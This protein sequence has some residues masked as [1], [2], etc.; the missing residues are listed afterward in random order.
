MNFEAH[1][2]FGL[3]LH[4][5]RGDLRLVTTLIPKILNLTMTPRTV[6]HVSVSLVRQT[7]V[8]TVPVTTLIAKMITIV[9]IVVAHFGGLISNF[10]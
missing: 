7:S 8:K 1:Q 5:L 6:A 10:F 4:S 3:Y 2:Q 9:S